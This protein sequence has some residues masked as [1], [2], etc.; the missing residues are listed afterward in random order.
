M[1]S[2]WRFHKNGEDLCLMFICYI[3]LGR[4]QKIKVLLRS[5][6]SDLKNILSKKLTTSSNSYNFVL[7][8]DRDVTLN[9]LR[10]LLPFASRGRVLLLYDSFSGLHFDIFLYIYTCN[11]NMYIL[12]LILLF[13]TQYFNMLIFLFIIFIITCLV[14]TFVCFTPPVAFS[15]TDNKLT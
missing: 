8:I 2:V 3:V 11:I 9:F 1:L 14:F 15:Y 13:N 6:S 10:L 12:I 4:V 5:L 7:K